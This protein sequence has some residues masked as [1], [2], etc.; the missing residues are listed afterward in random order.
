MKI[1]NTLSFITILL[2][3]SNILA[4]NSKNSCEKLMQDGKIADAITAAKKIK[5]DYDK[6]FCLGKAYYRS[7]MHDVAV[8]AFA[9]SEEYAKLPVDQMFSMLYKG[10][11]ER[12]SG[13]LNKSTKTL[14]RGLETAKL[15]NSKYMQM[16]RRF[17][18]QLGQ[19][20]L[21][22]G[23][24]DD[25]VDYF[26]KSIVISA[27]DNERAE[28]Y[29]GLAMAYYANKKAD[30]AIEYGIKAS[31]MYLK[32]GAYNE[33]ADAQVKLSSYHL[34]D[35]KADRAL[36]VLERLEKFAKDNGSQYYE[37]TALIEQS[38]V[39]TKQGNDD[40]AKRRL[41]NGI[42]IANKIG[43]TNLLPK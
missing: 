27:N 5:N 33:Y 1:E 19:N 20:N 10:I 13:N 8:K 30:K 6:H 16:E 31:N 7:N 25:S 4:Y 38:S 42:A 12:G 23:K 18:Y 35:D 3:S 37:A 26:A 29:D 2:F 40:D 9:D 15:G 22:T 11:A 14:T 32:T 34:G 43:A 36:K 21:S 41:D 24:Y 39:L 17:L 28:G